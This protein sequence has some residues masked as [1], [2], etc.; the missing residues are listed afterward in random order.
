[1]L[2]TL[3]IRSVLCLTGCAKA[4]TPAVTVAAMAPGYTTVAD[5]CPGLV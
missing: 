4:T 3:V 2:E 5:A 1:M